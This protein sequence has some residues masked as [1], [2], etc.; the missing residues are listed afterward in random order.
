M[1][2]IAIIGTGGYAYGL[3]QDIW[4]M[5]EKL[6]LVAA[7]SNP[8]RNSQGAK[9]CREKGIPVYDDIDKMLD[10]M[11]GKADAIMIP[12]PINTHF[13]LA[14]KC[15]EAGFDVFLEKPPVATI[16]QHE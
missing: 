15:L 14:K 7:R 13:H 8:K 6:Q 3:I 10:D 12:T 2:R 16:Q 5:P 11:K 9:E 1:I 4:K